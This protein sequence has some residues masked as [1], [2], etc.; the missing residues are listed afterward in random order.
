MQ[1]GAYELMPHQLFSE[2]LLLFRQSLDAR[3]QAIP[4]AIKRRPDFIVARFDDAAHLI[5]VP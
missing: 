3:Q 2:H 1:T 5:R 4:A